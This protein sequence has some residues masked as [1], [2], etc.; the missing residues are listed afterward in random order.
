VKVEETELQG[1]LELTPRRF[2]DDRGWF[3]EVWNARTFEQADLA[4]DWVQD[5][6][7][8]SNAQH[9]IRGLHFQVEPLAQA[10]LVRVVHGRILDVAVDLRRSS[11]TF[12]R[13]VARELSA[14]EGN[15]IFVPRGFAH[16][17]CTLEPQCHVAYKVDGF[18]SAAHERAVIWN[19]PSIAID[20]GV[21]SD[22]VVVSAKDA[23]APTLDQVEDLFA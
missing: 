17:F 9:T 1:V 6:E 14:A 16:G 8:V 13:W 23:V 21:A 22:V 18:Y 7:S 15:Q 5:N 3:S 12:G 19:D 10:K 11:P 2:S 20:W 4:I